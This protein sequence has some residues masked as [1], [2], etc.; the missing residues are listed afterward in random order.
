MS[1]WLQN[2]R[3]VKL[4]TQNA[5]RQF[6]SV[7]KCTKHHW[8]LF[9]HLEPYWMGNTIKMPDFHP[10]GLHLSVS[11]MSDCADPRADKQLFVFSVIVTSRLA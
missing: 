7:S 2:I 11:V 3:I 6:D 4:E 1:E 5:S 9:T 8:S 10:I